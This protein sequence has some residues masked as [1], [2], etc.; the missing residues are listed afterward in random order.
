MQRD[1]AVY[2]GLMWTWRG[3]FKGLMV[4]LLLAGL[5][6]LLRATASTEPHAI[7]PPELVIVAPPALDAA[8]A[9]LRRLDT[10]KLVTVMRLLGLTEAGPPI[11]VMLVSEDSP[12]ARQSPS[13]VAGFADGDAGLIVIF[14]ARTPSYP[15]DSMEALLHHEVTHVL[16]RRAAPGADVPRWFHE[17]LAMTLEHTWGLRDR[18]ELA[19]AVVGGEQTLA[20]LDADFRGSAATAA[21]AYGVA[22]AFV[23]DLISRHGT[24]FPARLLV[25]MRS[26]ARFDEAFSAATSL[27]LADAERLFWRDSW[28]YRVV[29]VLTSSIV[30]W[31]LIVLLAVSARRRRAKRRRALREQWETEE[32]A[33][34]RSYPE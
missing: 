7:R 29:P 1:R 14:P 6:S 21:R 27:P 17:G 3:R 18:S 10:Q 32:L 19:L 13:W 26:G 20:T 31:M 30:L 28:W 15:Y 5:A 12:A 25:S 9:G 24:E 2:D 33:L 22:G 8:A 11:T 23:R 16:V 34:S 4:G